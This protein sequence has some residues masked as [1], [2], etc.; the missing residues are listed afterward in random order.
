[1]QELVRRHSFSGAYNNNGIAVGLT[2]PADSR[3]IEETLTQP[4]QQAVK[5]RYTVNSA[6]ATVLLILFKIIISH[7]IEVI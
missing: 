1:M 4:A 5:Y 2:V 6:L 3:L 7:R